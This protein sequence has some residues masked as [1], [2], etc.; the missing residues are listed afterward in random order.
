MPF[1]LLNF[2]WVLGFKNGLNLEPSK[3]AVYTAKKVFVADRVAS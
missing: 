2:R 1:R 3:A